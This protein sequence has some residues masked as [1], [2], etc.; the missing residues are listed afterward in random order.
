MLVERG[1]NKKTLT[2][3]RSF[4]SLNAR[5]KVAI[6]PT[7]STTVLDIL[8][9][10]VSILRSTRI[11]VLRSTRM[12][13]S[14]SGVRS[15]GRRRDR[16][17]SGGGSSVGS[18]GN[19]GRGNGGVVSGGSLFS[20]SRFV[21]E[22]GFGGRGDLRSGRLSEGSLGGRSGGGIGSRRRN[23]LGRRRRSVFLNDG[24]LS[25]DVRSGCRLSFGSR[26]GSM[27]VL[28]FLD[29]LSVSFRLSSIVSFRLVV[30]FRLSV[31][32]VVLSTAVS[33]RLVAGRSVASVS[34]SAVSESSSMNV[35]LD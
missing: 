27:N 3:E 9:R 12:F 7:R 23:V 18:V 6:V 16:I 17:V 4:A 8:P 29:G 34:G 19:G 26:S 2:T 30:A 15:F 32:I 24:F 5:I 21:G 33:C 25:S 22:S 35:L 14:R 13:G 28:D 11:L 10:L 20:R 31:R 1:G